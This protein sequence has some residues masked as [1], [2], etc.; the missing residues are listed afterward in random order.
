[1]AKT[2]TVTEE[3]ARDPLIVRLI[4]APVL[5]ISFLVSL[6]F[7][8]QKTYGG[9]FGNSSNKDG[10]YH[11]HQRK[12]A[13]REMDDAFQLRQKVIAAMC[14]L[15]AVSVA[16]VAWGVEAVWTVWRVKT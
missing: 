10:Y 15:A 12:L 16:L 5:F 2:A 13:K 14:V 11:S 9:I 4:V 1:M 8:D 3:V 6:F 7:I